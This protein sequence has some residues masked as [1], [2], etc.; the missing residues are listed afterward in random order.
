LFP[1]YEG[2]V[3]EL[4]RRREAAE[5]LP[6]EVVV[7]YGSSS[8]RLWHSLTEDFFDI[9]VLNMGFGGSTLAACSYYFERLIVPC[10]PHT[11]VCY[12]GENDIGDGVKPDGVLASFRSLHSK[13]NQHLGD[14]P[15]VFLS[16]KPSPARWNVIDRV[17]EVNRRIA[18]EIKCRE[19]SYFLDVHTPMLRDDGTPRR[20]LW[21]EDNIHMNSLGYHVWWQVIASQRRRIGF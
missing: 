18:D 11:L 20:E 5:P 3:A 6:P 10:A 15:F 7:F 9:P 21:T 8:I 17:R 12:A 1:H 13:V 2:E 14:R 4:A 16:V 19:H